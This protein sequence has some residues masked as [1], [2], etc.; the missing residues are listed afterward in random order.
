M[1]L[2]AIAKQIVA[3]NTLDGGGHL[4]SAPKLTHSQLLRLAESVAAEEQSSLTA[5]LDVQFATEAQK[6]TQGN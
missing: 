2:R 5:K 4:T 3:S 1:N 6:Y